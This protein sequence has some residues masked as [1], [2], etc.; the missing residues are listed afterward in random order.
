MSSLLPFIV[1]GIANGSVYAIAGLGLVLT[2]RTSGIFNFAHGA[3]AALGAYLMYELRD[4]HGWPWPVAALASVAVAGVLVGF[5]LERLAFTLADAPTSTRVVATIGVLVAVQ[6]A[7][8]AKYGAATIPFRPFLS[9][10]IVHL[11]GVNIRVD[12]LIVTGLALMAASGLFLFFRRSRMGVAMQGV[13]DDPALLGLQGTSPAA[14]R[15]WA[16]IVGSCFASLS[17]ILLA[18]SIGLDVLILTLLVVQAFGAAA[19]GAF[20]SLVGTYAGGLAVGIGAALATKYLAAYPALAGLPSTLPFLVLFVALLVTPRR[21][22]IERG[23]RVVRRA[24]VPAPLPRPVLAAAAAA[25]TVALVAAPQLVS[26]KLPVLTTGLAFVIIFTSL[27]LLARTSGQVSLC[28][29]AFAAVGAAGF[30]RA[31]DA[32]APWLVAVVLGGL[33]AV[34]VGAVVAIPAIRLSGVYLAVATFGFGILMERIF[35]PSWLMFGS[36]ALTVRRPAVGHLATDTGYYYVLVAVA[37]ACA[38]LA[39]LVR[40]SRLGRLLRGLADC[41]EALTA[42]GAD[43]NV[44]RV[45]VFCIS[46]LLAGVGGAVL[47]PVTGSAGA[48]SFTF[49]ISLTLLAVLAIAGLRPVGSAFVAALLYAVLPG[50]VAA[51]WVAYVPVAFGLAA[52]AASAAPARILSARLVRSPRLEAR[53]DRPV[54]CAR[55]EA[56]G[57]GGAS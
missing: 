18:P 54:T 10:R 19:M 56:L 25:G 16:W 29:M 43:T 55:L 27:G 2:Y 8:A 52:I 42:F 31:A 14:V 28:H 26:G 41:P 17:G 1:V 53:R 23:A 46:A 45:F 36:G 48:G 5:L 12:Q 6:G 40:R 21:Y 47:G 24:A 13:V 4:L 49:G 20:N 9:E 30:A 35:F 22:L 37:L 33:L 34:P 11:P 7:L 51:S 44:T 32:G 50:S 39:V 3:Q 57:T 38:G 15:R